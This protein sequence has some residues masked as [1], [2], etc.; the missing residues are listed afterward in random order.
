MM[1][2]AA[3]VALAEFP[4][5]VKGVNAVS[6]GKPRSGGVN[7]SLRSEELRT[8]IGTLIILTDEQDRVRAV[9]WTDYRDRL[10]RLLRLHYG[11]DGEALPRRERSS[12]G[13]QALDAYFAGDLAALDTV[14]AATN[15]TEFQR[16]VWK[17]L[18]RIPAGAPWSYSQLAATIGR[19]AAVRAVGLANGANPIGI[20]VPCHRVIGANGS[21]TG[22]GGGIERKRWLLDFEGGARN[23]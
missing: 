3:G 13:A 5:T 15:G 22:Y 18:R 8:P 7:L 9:D 1:N 12:L 14:P 23:A 20:I 6:P 21:L 16:S 11:W 2:N 10:Q 19:P 4:A 17:A